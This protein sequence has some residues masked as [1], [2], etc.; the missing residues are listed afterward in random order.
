MCKFFQKK[1]GPIAPITTSMRRHRNYAMAGGRHTK[2]APEPLSKSTG[3][4]GD[5]MPTIGTNEPP[6]KTGPKWLRNPVAWRTLGAVST[7]LV[8]A[9]ILLGVNLGLAP[10]PLTCVT[11]EDCRSVAKMNTVLVGVRSTLNLVVATVGIFVLLGFSGVDIKVL[12]ASAGLIGLIAGLAAQSL[13]RSF[14]M[15][16]VILTGDRFYIGDFVRLDLLGAAGAHTKGLVVDFNLQGTTIQG[17]DG[18]KHFVS[19]G[20]IALVTN[21][22]QGPQRATIDL[23]V[24]YSSPPGPLLEV[25]HGYMEDLAFDPSLKGDLLRPPVVKGITGNREHSY[26]ITVTA[27]ALPSKVLAVERNMRALLLQY[28][29]SIGVHASSSIIITQPPTPPP[30]NSHPSS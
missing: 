30:A 19:N 16:L 10:K 17:L 5:V 14:M 7:I 6:L 13:L 21:Y 1:L 4:D 11:P 23:S 9:A 29:S 2:L 22:S 24:S 27:T 25:L 20:D 8:T 15:G 12:L 3:R 26:V 28:L 18:A